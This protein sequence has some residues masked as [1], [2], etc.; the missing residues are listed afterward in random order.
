MVE[1]QL[2]TFGV[3]DLALLAAFAEIPREAYVAPAYAS[4]AYADRACPALGGGRLLLPPMMLGRLI[5]AANARPGERAL[6][7]AGGSGYAAAILA[8]L[9]VK[10][11]ALESEDAG[12]GAKERFADQAAVE[13]IV[14]DLASGAPMQAPF[15]V[16]VVNGAFE[17]SPDQL[18]AQ[19]ADGGRLVGVDAGFA[20]PKAVLI[21][22]AGGGIS[23]RA[24]F[25]AAAPRLASF[26]RPP[27]FAF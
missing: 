11:V 6:D 8:H 15:D 3:T 10:V 24:L 16:I 9:G 25:D 21:E 17:L 23:K 26:H 13:A 2:R 14:G 1:G 22:K 19:L 12:Q 4:L 27:Q 5:Q 7:V 20:A 18:I